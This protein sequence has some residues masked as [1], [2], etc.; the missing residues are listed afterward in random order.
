GLR[1][2]DL[3]RVRAQQLAAIDAELAEP[4]ATAQRALF[5]ALFGADHPY[6]RAPTGTGSKAVVARLSRADLMAFHDAWLRPDKARII[7]AGDTT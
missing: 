5:P 3:E 7:V 1:P 4:Q 6:G 2:A